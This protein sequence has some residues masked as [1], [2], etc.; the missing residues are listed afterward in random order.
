M[1]A[2]E[3][4]QKGGETRRNLRQ[5]ERAGR[6]EALQMPCDSSAVLSNTIPDG[7]HIYLEGANG[8]LC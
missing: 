5:V 6:K 4:G 2:Q 8:S 7:S 1:S 3:L